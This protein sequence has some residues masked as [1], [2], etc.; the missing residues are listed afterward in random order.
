MD[1]RGWNQKEQIL[2]NPACE[3]CVT[4][5]KSNEYTENNALQEIAFVDFVLLGSLFD[6]IIAGIF[7]NVPIQQGL[8]DPVEHENARRLLGGRFAPL[9][10]GV[11]GV[12]GEL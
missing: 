5:D 9:V 3:G 8:G 4:G 1:K 6:F 2:Q 11:F 12:I 7:P 10:A